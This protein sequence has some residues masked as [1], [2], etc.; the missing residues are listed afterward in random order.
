MK[1]LTDRIRTR[2]AF[3]SR[4]S[5]DFF[6]LMSVNHGPVIGA[7][8]APHIAIGKTK[9]IPSVI[10]A[11]GLPVRTMRARHLALPSHSGCR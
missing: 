10:T 11:A 8:V 7:P 4:A 1:K 3:F 2:P 5:G 9:Q 6:G